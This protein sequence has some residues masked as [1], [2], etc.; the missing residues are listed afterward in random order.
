MTTLRQ[1]LTVE[2]IGTFFLVFTVGVAV[3]NAGTLAPLAIGSA[4]MVMVFA[5]GH[6]SGAHYNPAVSTAVFGRGKM[7]GRD[8]VSYVA[9]QLVA[10][11]LAG[12]VVRGVFSAAPAAAVAGAGKMLLVEA[13]FT[14]ALAYV[15]L[16]VA[17]AKGTENNSFYGLAIGFTV[18]T[19]AFAVGKISGGVF[20]PAV[21]FGGSVLGI[22][23]WSHIW[24]YLLA[25]I[26]AGA[27]AAGVFLLVQPAEKA[28]GQ[29]RAAEPEADMGRGAIDATAA[30]AGRTAA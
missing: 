11:V 14:F 15:V 10:G 7:S 29:L 18:A 4:L 20:N 28:D 30:Q 8:Y 27:L 19:G 6:I 23:A 13:L 24:I 26:V 17:T 3:A 16:N 12:L 2:F 25:E 22:F 21:A 1:K 9:T 5:G